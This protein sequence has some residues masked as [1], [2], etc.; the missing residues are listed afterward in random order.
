[1]KKT[2]HKACD[3]QRFKFLP[4][5]LINSDITIYSI[6]KRKQNLT[7]NILC[8]DRKTIRKE[9]IHCCMI[10][11]YLWRHLKSCL[12]NTCQWHPALVTTNTEWN[13]HNLNVTWNC[14]AYQTVTMQ[15]QNILRWSPSWT[16]QTF[17]LSSRGCN[18]ETV[19]QKASFPNSSFSLHHFIDSCPVG[20]SMHFSIILYCIHIV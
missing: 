4:L 2:N 15:T 18:S 7:L 14:P 3:I 17:P 12:C 11:I 8:M 10:H 19:L 5:Y 20:L 13:L 16:L 9:N 6:Y 1:V